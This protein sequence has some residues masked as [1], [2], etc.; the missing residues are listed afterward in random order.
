M[1]DA[2]QS[3][4]RPPFQERFHH[5][6]IFVG[7]RQEDDG[8]ALEF[9]RQFVE[10]GDLLDARSASGDPDLQ[11]DRFSSQ[12][13]EAGVGG[14]LVRQ[15]FIEM[16]IRRAVA[17]FDRGGEKPTRN[18]SERSTRNDAFHNDS[19]YGFTLLQIAGDWSYHPLTRSNPKRISHA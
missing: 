11:H 3:A 8:T 2:D 13:V 7:D 15:Q 17:H 12:R 19:P 14:G 16:N 6:P 10:V 1:R 4:D 18:Q 5:R 9:L